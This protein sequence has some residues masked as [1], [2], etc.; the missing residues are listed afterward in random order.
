MDVVEQEALSDLYQMLDGPKKKIIYKYL[1]LMN[2]TFTP[3][4]LMEQ[5]LFICLQLQLRRLSS[6]FCRNVN[7]K[8]D[9]TKI[10]DT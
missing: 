7:E 1:S 8:V 10:I 9:D 3:L 5:V 2:S 6:A 4:L